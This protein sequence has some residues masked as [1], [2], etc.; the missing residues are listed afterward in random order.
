MPVTASNMP[1]KKKVPLRKFMGLISTSFLQR[2]S[3]NCRVDGLPRR[4]QER[5]AIEHFFLEFLQVQIDGRSY[6]QSDELRNNQA[7]HHH[8]PQWPPRR[9]VSTVTERDGKRPQQRCC[10][11]HHDRPEAFQARVVNCLVVGNSLANP[12][13]RA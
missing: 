2:E 9:S 8:E 3:W 6:K 4:A 5:Y 12:L 11:R 10:S 1:R 13:F 7:A